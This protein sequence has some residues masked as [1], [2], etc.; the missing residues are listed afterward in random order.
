MTRLERQPPPPSYWMP[1][2]AVHQIP[3]RLGRQWWSALCASEDA[4]VRALVYRL[5][6]MSDALAA[7]D[8]DRLRAYMYDTWAV[9]PLIE[10]LET[11]VTERRLNRAQVVTIEDCLFK[12]CRRGVWK[13]LDPTPGR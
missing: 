8:E 5:R 4:S 12:D 9:H 1:L 7:A 13:G 11:L 10:G 6:A 3:A 2:C